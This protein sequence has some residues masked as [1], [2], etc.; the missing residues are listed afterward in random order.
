MMAR[1]F[2]REKIAITPRRSVA[3]YALL[4]IA[5]VIVS[6]ILVIALAAACVYLPYLV[7]QSATHPPTQLVILFLGGILVAGAMLWSLVPR[8]EKFEPPGTLLDRDSH[9]KLFAE[10]EDIAARLNEPLPGEVYLIGQVNAFVADR[11][12]I[13]GFG[14]RRIMAVGLPL[15]SALNVSEFRGV[16][17]HEF[18]HYYSGDTS[19]GPWVYKT[20]AAMIRTF[21]SIGSLQGIRVGAI[22]LVYGLI[23]FVL[24][25]YF[26]GFLRV[27]NFVSRKKEHRADELACLVAGSAACMRGMRKVHGSSMAWMP[28]WNSEVAPVLDQDCRPDIADGFARFLAAPEIAAQVMQGI[29][30]EI[31]E[32]KTN[33]YDTHPPMRDRIAAIERFSISAAEENSEPALSLLGAPEMVELQFLKFI[34][35]KLKED[36]LRHVGWDVLGTMVTIPAWK[37]AVAGHGSLLQGITA[38]TLPDV[39]SRLP[40]IGRQIRDPQGMLLTPQQRA[41]RAG[42]LLASAL[43]LAL[44]DKGWRLETQP[45]QFRFHRGSEQINV[46]ALV[47]DLIAGKL[48]AEVWVARCNELRITGTPLYSGVITPAV[49]SN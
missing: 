35:P 34:N 25:Q 20:Q 4:S 30:K 16:V 46:F 36:S 42:S 44:L 19:I 6:Y 39:I 32:G 22:Q 40:D 47:D 24:K 9:P 12:G 21:Q 27:V 7:L 29:E 18:G 26:V 45:G 28:Y 41:Q 11:G 8:R 37:S 3:L 2:M 49:S 23:S 43:A 48:S 33:P 10:L 5:M 38:E 15:L 13:L 17:A 1:N 14:S 31:A